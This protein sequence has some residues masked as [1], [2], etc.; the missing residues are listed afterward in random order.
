MQTTLA[1]RLLPLAA[2]A[3]SLF[4]ATAS[5]QG[6]G[7]KEEGPAGSNPGEL[8]SN[9]SDAIDRSRFEGLTDKSQAADSDYRIQLVPN[10]EAGTLAVTDNGIGMTAEEVETNLGTVASS[11]TKRFLQAMKDKAGAPELIGQFGVGFYAAFMVA[12]RV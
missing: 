7:P 12:D 11:G 1:K 9:A 10:K 8:L 2:A 5:A 3:L 6:R 4:T